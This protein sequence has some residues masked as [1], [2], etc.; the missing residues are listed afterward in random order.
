[1]LKSK[2]VVSIHPKLFI[3][4]VIILCDEGVRQWSDKR[5][6]LRIFSKVIEINFP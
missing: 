6:N 2:R 5:A 4:R 3:F 1:M